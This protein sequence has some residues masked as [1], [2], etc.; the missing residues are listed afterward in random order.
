[1]MADRIISVT[2]KKSGQRVMLARALSKL[3]VCSRGEA[4]VT[5]QSGRVRVNGKVITSYTHW[6]QLSSDI[7]SLDSQVL[8]GVEE[9]TY[10]VLNKPHGYVTT[11]RDNYQ[12][13][14]VFDLLA[15]PPVGADSSPNDFAEKRR[16]VFA[17]GRLDYNSEGLLLFTNDGALGDAL[18]NPESHV[19]KVYRVL[20]DHLPSTEK[21]HQLESGVRILDYTTL[22]AK[23]KIE[24]QLPEASALRAHGDFS[25][26][27]QW[28]RIAIREGKN[29][30][31]RRMF[32]AMGCEV[33]RLI[34]IGFGSLRLGDLPVGGWRELREDEV[35][36]LRRAVELSRKLNAS[37]H[38][39]DTGYKIL[40][41]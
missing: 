19:Y 2:H 17:V 27:G 30:Q 4:K 25:Q 13:P 39:V 23:I 37:V 10:V 31:V 28:V 33:R 7:I 15:L 1:M 11:R 35:Q 16:W 14:T 5:I 9:F 20:L 24:G 40:E 29:R 36:A 8:P 26:R 38:E 21:L 34:R 32:A 3:G 41:I 22:P 18:I 6:V 12:R